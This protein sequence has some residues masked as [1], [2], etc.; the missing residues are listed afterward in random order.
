MT[1]RG[2]AAGEGPLR[3]PRGGWVW[4]LNKAEREQTPYPVAEAGKCG[5][6]LKGMPWRRR[7]NRW[8]S[9][10]AVH[11]SATQLPRLPPLFV[12]LQERMN[13]H[14]LDLSDWSLAPVLPMLSS[15]YTECSGRMD[16]G[17]RIT[18]RAP[19]GTG[20]LRRGHEDPEAQCNLGASQLIPGVRVVT[21][22]D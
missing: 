4:G 10:R 1:M 11:C 7:T 20:A 6:P 16:H 8:R 13:Q 14:A 18:G 15:Q 5:K 22:V 12:R 21:T 9:G 3:G 19:P 17:S 2:A